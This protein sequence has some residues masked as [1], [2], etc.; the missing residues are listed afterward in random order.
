MKGQISVGS[1]ETADL[2]ELYQITK[3]R[4]RDNLK[5]LQFG[6][7]CRALEGVCGSF[8]INSCA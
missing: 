5:V 8:D 4:L 2:S 1:L 6:R 3:G 7:I